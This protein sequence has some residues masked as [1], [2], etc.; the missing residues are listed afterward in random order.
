MKLCEIIWWEL[1]GGNSHDMFK[2]IKLSLSWENPHV[3]L[4]MAIGGTP[5]SLDDL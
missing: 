4:S 5:F 2:I 3:G 1:S